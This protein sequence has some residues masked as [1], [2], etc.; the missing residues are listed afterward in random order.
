MLR[1]TWVFCPGCAE[2][3]RS[4]SD[5]IRGDLEQDKSFCTHCDLE[6][7]DSDVCEVDNPD[8]QEE[9]S[10]LEDQL[11]ALIDKANDV[12]EK[13]ERHKYTYS[14]SQVTTGDFNN[15]EGNYYAK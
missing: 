10:K 15:N 7:E 11:L 3:Y 2:C 4:E 6:V 8:M 13:M 14:H 5:D 12:S 9:Y 1:N